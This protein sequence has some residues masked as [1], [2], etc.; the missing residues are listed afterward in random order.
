MIK[1]KTDDDDEVGEDDEKAVETIIEELKKTDSKEINLLGVNQFEKDDDTNHHIDFLTACSNLRAWN[2]KIQQTTR[3]NV[4]VKAGRIIA[5]LATTTAATTGLMTLEFYK[6]ILGYQYQSEAKFRNAQIDFANSTFNFWEPGRVKEIVTTKDVI[7]DKD[8]KEQT[9]TIYKAYPSK[10]STWDKIVVRK[11]NLTIP[12]F[13]ALFPKLHFGVI[14]KSLWKFGLTE[15]DIKLGKGKIIFGHTPRSTKMTKTQL[16]RKN[17]SDKLKNKLMADL[18][19]MEDFNAKISS[20]LEKKLVDVYV[21]EYGPLIS[22]DRNY[23]LLSGEF[24]T[25]ARSRR[26]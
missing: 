16:A 2:Y 21:E 18:K 3:A 26:S 15:A 6:L 14:V 19:E 7:V 22:G 5:A 20:Q 10:F 8:T 13:V 24:F 17:L 11:G 12:E 1:K 4:K 25:T 9:V 23:V